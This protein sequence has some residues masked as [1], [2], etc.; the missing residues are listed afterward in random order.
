[1]PPAL[2]R[3]LRTVVASAISDFK[4]YEVPALCRR[5]GLADGSEQEAFSSKFKYAQKRLVEANGVRLL[6]IARGLLGEAEHYALSELVS[7]VD[8][9]GGQE[10]TTLTRRRLLTLLS[11]QPLSTEIDDLELIRSVWPIARMAPR[12]EGRASLE[13]DIIK[14]TIANDDWSQRELLESLGCMTCSRRQLFKFLEA[15]TAP[16]SQSPDRQRL[17]AQEI[18]NILEHDGYALVV[19]GMIVRGGEKVGQ[20]SGGLVLLRGGVKPGHWIG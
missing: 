18:G 12:Y 7:K 17:L 8:E 13:E 5:L 2:L 19:D 4:A 16:E 6:E 9:L 11:S 10:I 3:E 15:L 1:M 14:H 20:W